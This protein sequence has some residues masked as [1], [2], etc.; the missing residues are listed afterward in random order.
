MTQ[1]AK[2][3]LSDKV[4]SSA[5]G[6]DRVFQPTVTKINNQVDLREWDSSIEDQY[7]LGSCVGSAITNCYELM[8]KKSCPI[9]FV[10]LSR[11]F[12]YYNARELEGT[13]DSDS[14]ATIR[15]GLKGLKRWG[16]CSEKCWPYNI[17]YYTVKP[18][19]VCYRQ[20]E[21]RKITS[22]QRVTGVDS[23]LAALTENYPVIIG[24]TIYEDFMNLDLQNSTVAL[25]KS[26]EVSIGSH[27][28]LL[29]GYDSEKQQFLAK[30]SFGTDWGAAGYCWIPFEYARQDV[31]EQ[32]IIN[33]D[34]QSSAAANLL[35]L[36]STQCL[37]SALALQA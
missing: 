8:V 29:V 19:A 9:Q 16:V 26:D 33:I 4:C 13:L 23:A 12:V 10:E 36:K 15:N 37:P 35:Y 32:W 20:A 21:S 18:S 28:M 34:C 5:D 27:A 31:F 17:Q 7:N 3:K 1:S 24:L 25:P 2:F 30:N 6:N 22:Y 14:G 11:L